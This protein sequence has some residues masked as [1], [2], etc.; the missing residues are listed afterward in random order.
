MT[1]ELNEMIRDSLKQKRY[2]LYKIN[3]R[4]YKICGDN[5]KTYIK[6]A[7]TKWHGVTKN[8][9]K[10]L[11]FMSSDSVPHGQFGVVVD[12]DIR[13]VVRES[14]YGISDDEEPHLVGLCCE[15]TLN[16]EQISAE[17]IISEVNKIKDI[18]KDLDNVDLDHLTKWLESELNMPYELVNKMYQDADGIDGI[19]CVNISRDILMTTEI[20]NKHK[21]K[22]KDEYE[23]TPLF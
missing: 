15:Q 7:L 9:C 4:N 1:N 12:T 8:D 14:W 19:K 20:Q 5:M 11:Y 22:P 21:T 17:N 23:E 18:E 2:V 10:Y 3:A 16:I 13:F 6:K